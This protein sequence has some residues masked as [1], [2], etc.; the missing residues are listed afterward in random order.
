MLQDAT[1]KQLADRLEKLAR[2]IKAL[3]AERR[4]ELSWPRVEPKSPGRL[5]TLGC[6]RAA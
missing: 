5:I 3:L 6:Q 1:D 4:R 2:E